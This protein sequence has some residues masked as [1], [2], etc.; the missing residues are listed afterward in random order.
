MSSSGSG[1]PSKCI[2][3]E[4]LSMTN[5]DQIVPCPA[6]S[7]PGSKDEKCREPKSVRGRSIDPAAW[8]RLLGLSDQSFS[9]TAPVLRL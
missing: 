1:V 4:A 8:L 6:F 5:S 9:V 3:L 2:D 7:G